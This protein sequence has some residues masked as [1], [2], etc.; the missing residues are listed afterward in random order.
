LYEEASLDKNE[1]LTMAIYYLNGTP[2]SLVSETTL[3]TTNVVD[4]NVSMEMTFE[5]RTSVLVQGSI[6]IGLII[7]M[8]ALGF[9][10]LLVIICVLH[11]VVA[12]R[13]NI[14]SI[15]SNSESSNRTSILTGRLR[16]RRISNMSQ[17]ASNLP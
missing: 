9:F 16:S 11:L 12:K 6:N 7:G 1:I 17:E 5:E 13:F 10:L 15:F 4:L 8:I 14:F 3:N 2:S